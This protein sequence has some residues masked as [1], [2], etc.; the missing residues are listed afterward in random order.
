MFFPLNSSASLFFDGTPSLA[1]LLSQGCAGCGCKIGTSWE[2]VVFCQFFCFFSYAEKGK[3]KNCG[4]STQCSRPYEKKKIVWRNEKYY[5]LNSLLF[6]FSHRSIAPFPP[7][8][9]NY[10]SFR[11]SSC[12]LC[13]STISS[14][15]RLPTCPLFHT[16]LFCFP[17]AKD[18]LM[19][20]TRRHVTAQTAAVLF[21]AEICLSFFGGDKI[22]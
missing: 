7:P 3:E 8:S 11:F 20:E 10:L 22:Y 4:G 21:M 6:Y 1:F 9:L 18:A 2:W 12:V 19:T 17:I 15:G 16:L 14:I 13:C 5:H